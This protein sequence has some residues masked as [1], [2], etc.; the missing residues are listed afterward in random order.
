MASGAF[1][2]IAL[3]TLRDRALPRLKRPNL[4]AVTG[5]SLYMLGFS[6]AYVAMDAG[7][8]ALILFGGVQLTMFAGS[9]LA[10]NRPPIQR[11][12]GMLVSMTGLAVLSFPS[13]SVSVD[14][15]ALMLMAIA[16]IGWGIYSLVGTKV[17]DPIAASAWNFFYTLPAVLVVFWLVPDD[18]VATTEGLILAILSGAI[19]SALGYALWYMLLPQ[20][21]ATKSALS[22]LSVPAIALAMGAALL[23][24]TV[25][26]VAVCA[27][28]LILGG[29]CIG[30]L[31]ISAEK[32]G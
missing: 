13:Q 26:M 24:E 19:T 3:L 5:L 22:Q 11:W 32:K 31:P 2:L 23:G 12:I 6:F 20:L 8:G 15:A 18:V 30:L 16:A 17:N 7:L 28:F 1:V 29:I 14:P 10:G 21:G 4:P 9:V 27:A 25:S